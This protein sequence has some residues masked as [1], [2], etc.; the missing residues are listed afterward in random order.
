MLRIEF[1]LAIIILN[2]SSAAIG[3]GFCAIYNLK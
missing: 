2:R 3:V 1:E